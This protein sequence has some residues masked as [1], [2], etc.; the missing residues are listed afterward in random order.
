MIINK[1][2]VMIQKKII[3]FRIIMPVLASLFLFTSLPYF[4]IKANSENFRYEDEDEITI[5]K[6]IHDFGT[7]TQDSDSAKAVFTFTNNSKVPLL[8]TNVG[9]SCG[10]TTPNW[11]K[12]PIDPGKTGV[13]IA[14]FNPRNRPGPF[15]KTVTILTSGNPNRFVV[16]IKG[17]VE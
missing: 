14:N 4:S 10:C 5:D 13:V 6:T 8:I 11:T 3:K 17:V 16:R 1:T 15:D 12:E 7:I 2:K 9:A